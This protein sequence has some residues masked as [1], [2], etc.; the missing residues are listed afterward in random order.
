MADPKKPQSDFEV[1]QRRAGRAPLKP[2]P[3]TVVVDSGG[4]GAD[5][6]SAPGGSLRVARP[7]YSIPIDSIRP[8]PLNYAGR[9]FVR[10][11]QMIGLMATIRSI[12]LQQ[13]I[14]VRP[15]PE[16]PGNGLTPYII[17]KGHRRWTAHCWLRDEDRE[18]KPLAQSQFVEIVATISTEVLDDFQLFRRQH[19]ENHF[20]QDVPLMNE[21]RSY[22]SHLEKLREANPEY[23]QNELAGELG[24][25]EGVLTQCLKVAEANKEIHKLIQKYDFNIDDADSL[26]RIW[27]NTIGK[28]IDDPPERKINA[29]RK[30][31]ERRANG[32]LTRED[33][34]DEAKETKK[35]GKADPERESR[36]A[37]PFFDIQ[38][39]AL[40]MK[41]AKLKWD[42]PFESPVAQQFAG[43]LVKL[44]GTLVEKY[45][46]MRGVLKDVLKE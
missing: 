15:D 8:D 9:K 38:A 2:L 36:R 31:A 19:A 17:V 37:K 35:K 1:L 41:S 5:L 3:G 42:E 28:G 34:R 18:N 27:D 32:E 7:E 21:V 43:E 12:G 10:D 33:L 26:V 39:D 25:N 4:P 22:L 6:Q 14:E 40:Q 30:L 23:G 24:L 13:A 11:D 20:R 45:P 16:Y 29:I 44:I 46:P